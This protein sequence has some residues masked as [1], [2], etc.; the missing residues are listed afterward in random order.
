MQMSSSKM[1][2]NPDSKVSYATLTKYFVSVYYETDST[3][4]AGIF[5]CPVIASFS[6]YWDK[7][8]AV[9]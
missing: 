7:I 2:G 4:G 1:W 9:H 3:T 8:R 6:T 5:F